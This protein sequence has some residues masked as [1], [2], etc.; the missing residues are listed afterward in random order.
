MQRLVA[1]FGDPVELG[2]FDFRRQWQHAAIY[3]ANGRQVILRDPLSQFHQPFV[4][5]RLGI[6][7]LDHRLRLHGGRFIMQ[8]SHH[9]GDPLIAKRDKHA[10]AH[11]RLLLGYFVGE[12]HVQWDRQ[13]YVTEGGHELREDC[14][15][16]RD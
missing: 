5:N 10:S 4:Q 7:Y 15:G 2:F 14:T 11:H 9:A 8:G 16:R 1:N 12:C 13:C 6:Q 3:I